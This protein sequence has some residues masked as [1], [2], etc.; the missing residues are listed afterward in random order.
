ML[1]EDVLTG[2]P[3]GNETFPAEAAAAFADWDGEEFAEE[4]DGTWH[5]QRSARPSHSLHSKHTSPAVSSV[6]DRASC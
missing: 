1:S 4:D 5:E 3:S 2:C 6:S